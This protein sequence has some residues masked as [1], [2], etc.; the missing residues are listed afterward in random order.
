MKPNVEQAV[1]KEIPLD[2]VTMFISRGSPSDRRGLRDL[3]ASIAKYGLIIPITVVANDDGTYQVLSGEGRVLAHRELGKSRIRAVVLRAEDINAQEK[4][5]TWVTVNQVR[6][7]LPPV[8]KARLAAMDKDSGLSDT[9]IARRYGMSVSTARQY[10][11][12]VRKASPQV[13]DMIE[14]EGLEFTKARTIAGAIRDK[15]TQESVA[16]VVADQDM[17]LKGTNELVRM[18]RKQEIRNGKP[19]TIPRIKGM[20]DQRRHLRESYTQALF[21]KNQRRAVLHRH[22]KELLANSDFLALVMAAGVQFPKEEA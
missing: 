9:E 2:R 20:I 7:K 12:T 19:Q 21:G 14:K 16:R 3:V 10:V 11:D 4:N 6:E 5:V 8:V 1:V 13:L 22:T 18:V 17:S 15:T